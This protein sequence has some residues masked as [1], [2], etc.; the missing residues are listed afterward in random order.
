MIKTLHLLGLVVAITTSQLPVALLQIGVWA[1]MFDDFYKETLS[2]VASTQWTFD[3]DHRCQ[4]CELVSDITSGGQKDLLLQ[5]SLTK[6]VKLSC[7]QVENL[8]FSPSSFSKRI[9][10]GSQWNG[11]FYDGVELPPPRIRA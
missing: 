11:I 10:S 1:S 6:E 5:E 7:V 3:G 9:I 2:V 8:V 4:G